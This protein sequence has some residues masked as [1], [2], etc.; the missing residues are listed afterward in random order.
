MCVQRCSYR[1]ARYVTL[2]NRQTNVCIYAWTMHV[3]RANESY[4]L[5]HPLGGAKAGHGCLRLLAHV[6]QALPQACH[7]LVCFLPA[8]KE[9]THTWWDVEE[10]WY[11]S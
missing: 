2:I 7:H 11:K 9:E 10:S 8:E 1:T 6:A 4:L 5:N 3:N